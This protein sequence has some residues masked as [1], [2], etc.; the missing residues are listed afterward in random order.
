MAT[1]VRTHTTALRA[2]QR[3]GGEKAKLIKPHRRNTAPTQTKTTPRYNQLPTTMDGYDRAT[4]NYYRGLRPR[5]RVRTRRISNGPRHRCIGETAYS[6]AL[7]RQGTTISETNFF[8][9][10]HDFPVIITR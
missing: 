5:D 7:C 10:F 4:G 3:T 6:S 1:G 8:S 9:F 2:R